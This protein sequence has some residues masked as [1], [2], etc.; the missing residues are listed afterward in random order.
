MTNKTKFLGL[1][2]GGITGAFVA[3]ASKPN[4]SDEL[5]SESLYMERASAE[6]PGSFESSARETLA[7]TDT[8]SEITA[9][10]INEARAIESVADLDDV[11][12]VKKKSK[13]AKN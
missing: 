2:L 3:N 8:V 4:I 6:V 9:P 5:Y 11:A 1:L 7:S 12:P 13:S 10:K